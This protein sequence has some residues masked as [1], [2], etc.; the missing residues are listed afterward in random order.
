MMRENVMKEDKIHG[1]ILFESIHSMVKRL[2]SSAVKVLTISGPTRFQSLS[3]LEWS[4]FSRE[5]EI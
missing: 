1:K 3:A 4:Q 2:T 5:K